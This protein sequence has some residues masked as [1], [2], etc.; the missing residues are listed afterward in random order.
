MSNLD[1]KSEVTQQTIDVDGNSD[2]QRL[3]VLQ[4]KYGVNLK[5]RSSSAAVQQIIDENQSESPE[6]MIINFDR[7]SPGYS[8]I[9]DK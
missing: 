5:V 1:E 9:Y 6:N 8:R 7:A 3:S 4:Q 2:E